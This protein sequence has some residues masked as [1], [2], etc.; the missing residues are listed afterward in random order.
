MC[1][2]TIRKIKTKTWFLCFQEP[3]I[4]VK[5]QNSK[6]KKV[7]GNAGCSC[8][9]PRSSCCASARVHPRQSEFMMKFGYQCLYISCVTVDARHLQQRFSGMKKGHL[10][11]VLKDFN[12]KVGS[13][14][15]RGL[16]V[17]SYFQASFLRVLPEKENATLLLLGNCHTSHPKFCPPSP[18]KTQISF[19]LHL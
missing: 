19:R 17:S 15:F 9:P 3:V 12:R 16:T 7:L 14:L 5:I 10:N 2:S 4:Q 6:V 8:P 1:S 18:P 11:W 13:L